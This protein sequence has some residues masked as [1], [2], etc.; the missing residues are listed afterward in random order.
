MRS[1]ALPARRRLTS[2]FGHWVRRCLSRWRSI[3]LMLLLISTIGSAAGLFYFQYRPDRQ[4]DKA[5]AHEAI[6]A[7]SEGA[8]ALLSYS[9]DNLTRD[10]ENA[11][12]RLTENYRSYYNQFTAKIVAPA[13]QRGQIATT[14]RVIRAAVSEL[15]GNSAVVLMFIEQRTSSKEKPEP[16][17][18]TNSVRVMLLKVEGHWLIDKFDSL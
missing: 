17:K 10:F 15:H 11:K 8:V 9:P 18:T 7:A 5:A 1:D 14:A 4:T 6:R 2:S 3:V 13:A 16:L 12:W